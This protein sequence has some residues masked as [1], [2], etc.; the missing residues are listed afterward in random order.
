ML[1]Q[2]ILRNINHCLKCTYTS[3]NWRKK[4]SLLLCFSNNFCIWTQSKYLISHMLLYIVFPIVQFIF[5]N[6]FYGHWQDNNSFLNYKTYV[7]CVVKL[8]M[9]RK[10]Y[11]LSLVLYTEIVYFK[12]LHTNMYFEKG[13]YPSK[14]VVNGRRKVTI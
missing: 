3:I 7:S 13:S 10:F 12:F 8:I 1:E 6:L 2:I 5:F 14:L 11:S 9:S 4:F